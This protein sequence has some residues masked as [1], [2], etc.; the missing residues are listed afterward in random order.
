MLLS[1]QIQ[2]EKTNVSVSLHQRSAQRALEKVIQM[3]VDGELN[4]HEAQRYIS[5][6]ARWWSTNERFDIVLR[7]PFIVGKH[8]QAQPC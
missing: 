4:A 1:R 3:G 8:R 6:W 2:P 7:M 5:R